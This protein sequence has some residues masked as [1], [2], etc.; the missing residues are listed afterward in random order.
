MNYS[1]ARPTIKSGDLIA[2]SAGDWKSWHGIKIN[3]IRIFMRSTYSHVGV[4]WVISGRVF[5][6]EAVVPL[7]R[8]YPLSK[9]GNF[10]LIPLNAEWSINTEEYALSRIGEAYSQWDAIKAYF[11]PLKKGSVSECAAYAREILLRDGIDLGE[12]SRPDTVVQAAL[13]RGC[14]VKYIINKE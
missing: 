13:D 11:N 3:L 1:E 8:I 4:A 6:L 14:F 5:I 2:Y 12:L 7:T 10:Y 9:T